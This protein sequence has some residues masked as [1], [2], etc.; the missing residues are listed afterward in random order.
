MTLY[1]NARFLT[2]PITGVQRFGIELSKEL[3]LLRPDLRF[4]AP[5]N[6]LHV[7]LGEQLGVEVRGKLTGHAWE[8]LELPYYT[9]GGLLLNLC[10][11]APLAKRRQLVTLHDAAVLAVPKAY[12]Y[13]FRSWYSVLFYLLSRTAQEVLTVSTF[14]Q[15]ELARLGFDAAG[16]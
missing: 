5:R 6:I 12:S 3:K 2:Q 7:E 1:V 8:Q 4:V 16:G 9:R 11:T 14:S 13:A 10:N 15:R